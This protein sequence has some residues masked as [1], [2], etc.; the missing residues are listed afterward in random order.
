MMK[1]IN[2]LDKYA[3]LSI[4]IIII[5][6]IIRFYL[7]SIH[8]VSGDACWQL[9]NS[10]FIAENKRL[11]L[12]EQFGRDEPFWA[13][14]LFHLIAAFVYILF[15]NIGANAAEFT[16][17]MISPL[18][19]SLTLIFS[20][21]ISRKLFGKKIAF[22][23]IVFLAFIPLSLDYGVYSYIDGVI[24]FPAILGVYFAL[25]NR[26][27]STGIAAGLAIL[28]KY[29]GIFIAPVLAYIFYI[30]NKNNYKEFFKKLII[31]FIIAGAIGS[32]WFIRNWIYLGNPVWPFMNDVFKGYE[33]K[34]FAVSEVGTVKLS[35]IF[36]LN[37][38]ASIYLGI[39]GVPDGNVKALYFFNI[40]YLNILFAVWLIGTFIF[41]IPLI[42]GIFSGKL[43]HKALLFIWIISYI[44]LVLLYVVN[45]GWSVIRFMLPAFPAIALV[46]ACGIDSIKN[47]EF[48]NILMKIISLVIIGF[49]AASF[50]KIT[51]AA[52]SWSFYNEDFEWVKANTD[53]GSIF[54]T[55]SQCA[56]YNIDRQ[57]VSPEISNL[58]KADY[59]FVNQD[60][61]LDKRAVFDNEL[62]S[63]IKTNGKIIYANE[64]TK[65]E[66]YKLG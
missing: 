63:Q 29:N 9:S 46:W 43:K 7:A 1:R 17:K 3:R 40:P 26:A 65:T 56:S 18:F 34:S 4:I 19:S 59:A 6:I 38:I 16:V 5:G 25:E 55:G 48:R 53:K 14:P 47:L 62:V 42:V 10:R 36:S 13:P 37:A 66:I 61:K 28:M 54:F 60:F 11:P 50:V 32:I 15:N 41:L 58:P 39:F 31:I 35:N 21:L 44:I 27:I 57:T 30:K 12:F 33:A 49:V 22:Y 64:N 24:T 51:L 8:H 23:S 20:W 52:K 45:A 2:K